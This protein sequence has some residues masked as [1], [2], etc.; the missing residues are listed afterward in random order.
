MSRRASIEVVVKRNKTKE[1][2]LA[3]RELF[4]LTDEELNPEW[5]KDPEIIKRRDEL[6]KIVDPEPTEVD[7]F[8]NYFCQR[9]YLEKKIVE[10]LRAGYTNTAIYDACGVSV[11]S[12]KINYL[13]KKHNIPKREKY[14]SNHR[15]KRKKYVT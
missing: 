5:F 4:M 9:P 10:M 3:R 8:Q 2:L 11:G 1:Q 7:I 6:L 12:K 15:K 14:L 13:K